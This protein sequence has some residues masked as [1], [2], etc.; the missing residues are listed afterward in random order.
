[1]FRITT[2]SVRDADPIP[3]TG[4]F[5][6]MANVRG[7]VAREL[8]GLSSYWRVSVLDADGNVVGTGTRAGRN[9]TG[10][11]WVWDG[12]AAVPSRNR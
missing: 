1:M 6:T 10:N 3:V 7:H 12:A 8:R 4:E 2:Q 5:R 9:G 11:R